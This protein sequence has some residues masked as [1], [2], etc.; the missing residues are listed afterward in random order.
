[1]RTIKIKILIYQCIKVY[2]IFVFEN[3]F[4]FKKNIE[5]E[6]NRDNI[7]GFQI[8]FILKNTKKHKKR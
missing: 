7:F 8:Y 5:N 3:C 1:M 6:E 4:L 2:L